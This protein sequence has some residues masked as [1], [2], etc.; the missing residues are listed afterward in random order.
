MADD[1][2]PVH[3]GSYVRKNVLKSRN[4]TVTEVAKLIGVSR[5]GVSNFL[6]GKVSA[7]PDMAARFERAFGISAKAILDLQTAY[8]AQA[9]KTADA[10]QK[11]FSKHPSQ[12]SCKLVHN[13]NSCT[14]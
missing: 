7:T 3:P 11:A 5:P 10:A 8:D 14:H 9:D 2:S 4:L 12:R 6:N 1:S 13:D